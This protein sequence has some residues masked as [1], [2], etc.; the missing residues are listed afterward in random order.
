MGVGK[1]TTPAM[2]VDPANGQLQC[3]KQGVLA[4]Q[5]HH[6]QQLGSQQ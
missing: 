5:V 3:T 1:A 2:M 4:A 6:T